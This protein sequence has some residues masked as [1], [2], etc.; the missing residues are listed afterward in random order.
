MSVASSLPIKK[1]YIDSRFKS[2][3]SVSDSNFYVDLPTSI[4][5]PENTV[6]YIDDISIPVSWYTIQS[7]VN[8]EFV[9]RFNGQLPMYVSY[10]PPGNYTTT[11]LNDVLVKEMNVHETLFT[12]N[13]NV[14]NNTIGIKTINVNFSFEI[15]TDAQIKQNSSLPVNSINGIL[16][17]TVPKVNNINSPYVSGYVNL[18]PL[19]NVYMTSSNLG[20]YNSLN[21]SGGRSVIKKIPVTANFNEMLYYQTVFGADYIDVS[22]QTLSRLKFGLE[23]IY[24]HTIDLN[25]NHWSFSLVFSRLN[26]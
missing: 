26:E 6:C 7:G 8:D 14:L 16:N 18:I 3:D 4:T 23:D 20:S 5:F 15:L 22:R 13:P 24:G 9:F 21:I 2:S 19:R 11:T 25:N 17:N 10:I 1:I 12:A